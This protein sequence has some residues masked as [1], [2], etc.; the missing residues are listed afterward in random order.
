MLIKI[1][2]LSALYKYKRTPYQTRN[3]SMIVNLRLIVANSCNIYI[4][5]NLIYCNKPHDG[6]I[7][8]YIPLVCGERCFLIAKKYFMRAPRQCYNNMF[9]FEIEK[10]F[11][12]SIAL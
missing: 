9:V 6:G 7:I 8:I 2:Y 4:K 10:G 1:I 12:D 3:K 5:K 11:L